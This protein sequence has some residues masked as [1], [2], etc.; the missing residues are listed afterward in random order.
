[1]RVITDIKINIKFEV[2]FLTEDSKITELSSGMDFEVESFETLQETLNKQREINIWGIEDEDY[3]FI[4]YPTLYYF[5]NRQEE[6]ARIQ[7]LKPMTIEDVKK[8][9]E[10]ITEILD[11]NRKYNK[12]SKDYQHTWNYNEIDFF[13]EQI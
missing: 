3:D 13:I 12:D 10:Y 2:R 1:M 8:L 6:I 11:I 5:E 4:L 7:T 9:F